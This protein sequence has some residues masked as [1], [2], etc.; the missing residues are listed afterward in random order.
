MQANGLNL[1]MHIGIIYIT[2]SAISF[3]FVLTISLVAN[4]LHTFGLEYSIDT[5]TGPNF[6]FKM[7][8]LSMTSEKRRVLEIK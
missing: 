5:Y 1:S 3:L 7:I 4:V 2:C 6:E 8:Y